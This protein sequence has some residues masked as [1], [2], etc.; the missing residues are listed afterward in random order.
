[1]K[2]VETEEQ[3]ELRDLI[4]LDTECRQVKVAVCRSTAAGSPKNYA[5]TTTKGWSITK[6]CDERKSEQKEETYY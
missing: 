5:G 1:M 2:Y 4:V 6:I 3:R